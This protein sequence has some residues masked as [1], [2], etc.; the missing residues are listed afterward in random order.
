MRL[1]ILTALLY[2]AIAFGANAVRAE[3][4]DIDFATLM[5]QRDG[6]MRKLSLHQIPVQVADPGFQRADG[7][8]VNFSDSNGRF[9]LVNFWAT[10]C[11][12]CREEMPSLDRLNQLYPDQLTVLTIAKGRH[13][14]GVIDE[15]YAEINVESLPVFL[16][17]RSVL[18]N[19]VGVIGLPITLLLDPD[20]NEIGR[21]IGGAQWDSPSARALLESIFE[22]Y[23]AE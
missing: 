18:S 11:A 20:G 21:L 4:S 12:P 7:S 6:D 2:A 19:S 14:P 23:A 16:D 9:R 3:I 17:E 10:W 8:T 22:I 15:F 5:E 1:S 13:R